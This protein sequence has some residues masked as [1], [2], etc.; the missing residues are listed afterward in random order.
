MVL[1]TPIVT[2]IFAAALAVSEP[3]PHVHHGVVETPSLPASAWDA[4]KGA[5]A[6]VVL[7]VV[8]V[9]LWKSLNYVIRKDPVWSADA[10]WFY[11]HP[12]EDFVFI[13]LRNRSGRPVQISQVWPLECSVRLPSGEVVS[14]SADMR[15]TP[16]IDAASARLERTPEPGKYKIRWYAVPDGVKPYELTRYTLRLSEQ[17]LLSVDAAAEAN[18]VQP[19]AAPED[20]QNSS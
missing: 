4:V 1:I 2:A 18:D 20:P 11:R 9:F 15:V 12:A 8:L 6:G 16:A 5:T 14:S 7:I 3:A 13:E 17:N 10:S 19:P